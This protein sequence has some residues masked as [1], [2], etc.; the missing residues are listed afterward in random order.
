MITKRQLASVAKQ[1][2]TSKL[3]VIRPPNVVP[4]FQILDLEGKVIGEEPTDVRVLLYNNTHT[5]THTHINIHNTA[6]GRHMPKDYERHAHI[7]YPG[8]GNVRGTA[9]RP[10]LLLHD[11]Y[12]GGGYRGR[13]SGGVA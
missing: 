3:Q 13:V 10:N 9:T 8:Q 6:R 1:L 12:G 5:Y 4:A 11:Q 2:Y 7:D